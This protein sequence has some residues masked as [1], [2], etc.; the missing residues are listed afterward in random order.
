MI[1]AK[2]YLPLLHPVFIVTHPFCCYFSGLAKSPWVFVIS[3]TE[4]K[5]ITGLLLGYNK[6]YKS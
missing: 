3:G 1:K 2:D 4:A 5:R 6:T